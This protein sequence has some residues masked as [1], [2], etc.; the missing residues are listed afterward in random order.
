MPV[1]FRV[2]VLYLVGRMPHLPSPGIKLSFVLK[3]CSLEFKFHV[4]FQRGNNI[5]ILNK[6][7]RFNLGNKKNPISSTQV[8]IIVFF[9]LGFSHLF[10]EFHQ[11]LK[12][13]LR[14][15]R[16][17]CVSSNFLAIYENSYQ[18]SYNFTN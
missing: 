10:D 13:F 6:F 1:L 2:I 15:K 7:T 16:F 18:Y 14:K 8:F 11:L 4:I 12:Y 5:G 3:W 17:L 9:A